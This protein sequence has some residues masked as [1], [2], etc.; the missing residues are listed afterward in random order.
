MKNTLEESKL[1]YDIA[2]YENSK[3]KISFTILKIKSAL[4]SSM[5]FIK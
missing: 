4:I 5:R 1:S 2:N 3:K